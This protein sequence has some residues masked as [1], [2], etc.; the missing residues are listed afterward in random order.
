MAYSPLPLALGT[1]SAVRLD[2][3]KLL[4]CL[5]L[6]G[7]GANLSRTVPPHASHSEA[8]TA[9]DFF[10]LINFD[11]QL[12]QLHRLRSRIIQKDLR[13]TRPETL[14]S[15]LR[16]QITS[17]ASSAVSEDHVWRKL[18]RFCLIRKLITYKVL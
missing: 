1:V 12:L 18:L 14:T 4:T 6:V 13:V 9:G 7:N 2:K 3:R 17:S 8:Q 16:L 5:C 15:R 11:T 10:W